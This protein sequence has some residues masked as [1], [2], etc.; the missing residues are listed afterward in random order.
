MSHDD[1]PLQPYV[2]VAGEG[3]APERSALKA[4]R[5]STGGN[6]TLIESHTR[7]GA[8]LHVHSLDD[9]YF[10]VLDGFISVQIG[11]ETFEVGPR[12]FVFF[13]RGIPHSWDVIREKNETATLLMMTVPGGLDE[14]LDEYHHAIADNAPDSVKDQ[15]NAKFGITW[16]NDEGKQ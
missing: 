12:G 4:S 13:P 15:I 8:P 6:F 7:G 5:C 9:E 2:L 1:Q 11:S 16:L 10:Y 3:I 14:F